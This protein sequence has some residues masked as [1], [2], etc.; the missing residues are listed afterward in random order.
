M[1]LPFKKEITKKQ[2]EAAKQAV[3]DEIT[4]KPPTIG[5]IGVSGVG[6][7]ST[8]NALFKT[9]L[10]VSHVAACTTE[11]RSIP[12]STTINRGEA[13]GAQVSLN[14][15][16]APGLGE[17]IQK[18]PEYLEMYQE[19]LPACDVILWVLSARNR[20]IALDQIYL[21]KL[22]QFHGKIVFGI[23]QIDLVEPMDWNEKTG[24]PSEEQEKN[25]EIIL[26]DRKAKLDSIM[27]REIGIV[28]YSARNRYNLQELFTAMLD[29][30]PEDR[31]WIFSHIKG[32]K[33]EDFIPEDI[34]NQVMAMMDKK[35][36][37]RGEDGKQ[38]W[39]IYVTRWWHHW[40]KKIK[41]G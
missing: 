15:A 5:L 6:K 40:T 37:K 8:L 29:S 36:E 28:T 35:E 3:I 1:E 27:E 7:S 16:D 32:F 17:S 34:R 11:F 26:K 33:P 39:K 30:C 41:N 25:C 19:N 12:L 21:E 13:E 9:D 14:V 4:R 31:A 23:N 10:P 18:D 38:H 24:M 22:R 2:L 20:A